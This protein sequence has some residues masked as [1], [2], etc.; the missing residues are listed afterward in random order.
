M[1]RSWRLRLADQAER[2]LQAIA[3]WTTENFGL[4]K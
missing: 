2:D 4:M 1:S 3:N